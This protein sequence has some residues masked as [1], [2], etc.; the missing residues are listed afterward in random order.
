MR[1]A[2]TSGRTGEICPM[3]T[4][5]MTA[6]EFVRHR[7]ALIVAFE[8]QTVRAAKAATPTIAI[9]FVHVTDP[10]SEGFVKSLARPGGNITG[11]TV[12]GDELRRKETSHEADAFCSHGV[13]RAWRTGIC[14]GRAEGGGVCSDTG[15]GR[16]GEQQEPGP[17]PGALRP[18]GRALGHRIPDVAR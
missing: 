18:R 1:K 6:Q 9:V 2:R 11:L 7:V 13:P 4:L 12:S 3:R 8:N 5:P 14:G 10:V 15:V 16:R 17:N